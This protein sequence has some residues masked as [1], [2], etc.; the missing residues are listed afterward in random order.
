[1]V[2]TADKFHVYKNEHSIA[3]TFE[4]YYNKQPKKTIKVMPQP[5]IGIAT[6]ATMQPAKCII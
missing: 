6:I 2:I 3:I 5:H 4:T 1:M